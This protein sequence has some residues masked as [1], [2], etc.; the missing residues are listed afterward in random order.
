[1]T[2]YL[3][4]LTVIVSLTC[5]LL[6]FGCNSGS[7]SDGPS[8][9]PSLTSIQI[10]PTNTIVKGISALSFHKGTTMKFVAIGY[11]S[12]GTNQNI[13]SSVDWNINNL[14]TAYNVG[15]GYLNGLN[16]GSFKVSASLKGIT[17]NTLD[18]AV[19]EAAVTDVHVTPLIATFP[20]GTH[21]QLTATASYS[22]ETSQDVTSSVT[23]N[24]YDTNVAT[25]SK[26]GVLSAVR[27]GYADITATIE[28]IESR[29]ILAHV[30]SA[31][32]KSITLNS[33]SETIISG[34]TIALKVTAHFG[35]GST[36][37]I[38][39]AITWISQDDTIVKNTEQLLLKGLKPGNTSVEAKWGTLLSKPVNITVSGA[40]LTDIE[41][42]P[43]YI[44]RLI[45]GNN[46]QLKATGTYSDGKKYDITQLVQWS[47]SDANNKGI[48]LVV[49]V[50]NQDKVH[51][52][53]EGN[54]EVS[55]ILGG[56]TSAK[57]V[58]ITV[59][60]AVIT[61]L[62]IAHAPIKMKADQEKQLLLKSVA[63]Y[64]DNSTGYADYINYRSSNPEILSLSFLDD[65]TI[66]TAH[67]A[68]TATIIATS[69]Q[70]HVNS[71]PLKVT[72]SN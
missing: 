30:T 69:V 48:P 53:K 50:D 11:Y 22:D 52:A 15:S 24:S 9:E 64:S 49:W 28:G 32:A 54:T 55:A 4:K 26:D 20:K 36:R 61:D 1:M 66:L 34:Q 27:P 10:A 8:S 17:S 31:E 42:S 44:A 46:A 60:R 33:N 45:K 39:Q 12:D 29:S 71:D 57:A 14:Y 65:H 43:P 21:E 3:K 2:N 18:V 37:D 25:I 63:T 47:M 67:Q 5:T 16:K 59:T 6:L 51:G 68:G 41:I 72:V 13:D 62:T 23:W 38:S 70:D 35:D 56:V 7:S 40:I 58:P 19:S